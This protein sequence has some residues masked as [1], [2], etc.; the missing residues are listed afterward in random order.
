[1]IYLYQYERIVVERRNNDNVVH[2]YN[3]HYIK[4]IL[5]KLQWYISSIAV[6]KSS[7]HYSAFKKEGGNIN[8]FKSYR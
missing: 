2:F 4:P 1:M 8:I 5:P 3:F 6:A 7:I